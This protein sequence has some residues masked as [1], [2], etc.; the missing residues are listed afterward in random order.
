[1]KPIIKLKMILGIDGVKNIDETLKIQ[2]I[3]VLLPLRVIYSNA[4]RKGLERLDIQKAAF[5]QAY[6]GN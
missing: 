2:L 5:V 4:K 3:K 1:M 6:T